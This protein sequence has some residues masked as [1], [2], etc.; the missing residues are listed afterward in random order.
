[1]NSTVG[2]EKPNNGKKDGEIGNTCDRSCGYFIWFCF[3]YKMN[4][5]KSN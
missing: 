4:E 2:F 3:A 5:K 1:M